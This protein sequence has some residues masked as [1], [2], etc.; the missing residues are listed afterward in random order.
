MKLKTFDTVNLST[1][2]VYCVTEMKDGVEV[3]YDHFTLDYL[4]QDNEKL[5]RAVSKREALKKAG[6]EVKFVDVINGKCNLT[7]IVNR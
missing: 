5:G 3:G 7:V 4:E 1:V 2:T 6:A